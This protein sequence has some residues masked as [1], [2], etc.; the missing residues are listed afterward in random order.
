MSLALLR[1][2]WLLALI[3]IAALA[4]MA[5]RRRAAG[6]WEALI[7]PELRA[8]LRA[9]GDLGAPGARWPLLVPFVLAALLA[10]ALSGPARP[11]AQGAAFARLDPLVI[12]LDL[13]P[14]V[15]EGPALADAQAAAAYLL[16]H[17]G[18]RPVGMI[19]YSSEAYLAS[20]PTSDPVTL[21]GL[22]AVLGAETMPTGGSRPDVVLS[23]AAELFAAPGMPGIGGADLVMI[24]D[25]GGVT[26]EARAAADQL[27]RRGARLWALALDRGAAAPE[28][29]P[30]DPAALDTLARAGG[31]SSG[32]AR[33]PGPLIEAIAAARGRALARSSEAAE[34]F[35]DLGRWLLLPAA[36][37]ALALFRRARSPAR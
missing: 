12:M 26:P 27:A 25:G 23:Q 34:I 17:A 15:S 16:A 6:G 37:L 21:Q 22:I 33:D 14:S 30:P 3:P 28:A 9:R 13:S 24:S 36:G 2:W 10:L 32:A 35:E 31:G 18:G 19:L 11:R 1:P 20:A 8:F 7:S 29:P 4:A 5:W